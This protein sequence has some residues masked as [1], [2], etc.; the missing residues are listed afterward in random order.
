M[1]ISWAPRGGLTFEV[2]LK[3]TLKLDLQKFDFLKKSTALYYCKEVCSL[4]S[5]VHNVEPKSS[6]SS[7]E[8]FCFVGL[9]S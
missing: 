1:D 5:K 6:K 4:S 8:H 2:L 7:Y 9:D 3:N